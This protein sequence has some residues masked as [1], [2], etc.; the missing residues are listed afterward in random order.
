MKHATGWG[1]AG[2][3]KAAHQQASATTFMSPTI[4]IS[5]GEASVEQSQG[6]SSP[7]LATFF[8]A[9]REDDH[10]SGVYYGG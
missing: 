2:R 4:F 6:S 8:H 9:A 5:A 3:L 1:Q 10:A 7:C